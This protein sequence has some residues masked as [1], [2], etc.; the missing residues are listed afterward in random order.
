MPKQ[1]K[2]AQEAQIKQEI[3]KAFEIAQKHNLLK[4]ARN[5][6]G[7]ESVLISILRGQAMGP[8]GL[9]LPQEEQ[10]KGWLSAEDAM[11]VVNFAKQ[12]GWLNRP[13]VPEGK[14]M[15]KAVK[16]NESQLRSLIQQLIE[17]PGDHHP[18]ES[19]D[20]GISPAA[21]ALIEQL[22]R[23]VADDI[24]DFTDNEPY[25]QQVP[26]IRASIRDCIAAFF[27]GF[28]G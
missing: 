20:S 17:A 19:D 16:L 11:F 8:R 21:N 7:R 14:N 23:Q 22:A 1:S 24:S 26:Q 10:M 6:G 18:Y 5:E 2:A 13:T 28:A 4:F 27:E 12:K 15:K 25:E 9:P 3:D